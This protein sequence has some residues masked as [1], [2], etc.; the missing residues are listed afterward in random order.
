MG[1]IKESW[2][3]LN[4]ALH[5]L[6]YAKDNFSK[7]IVSLNV[8]DKV[9]R[10]FSRPNVGVDETAFM[11]VGVWGGELCL[12]YSHHFDIDIEIWVM[13]NYGQSESW[14]KLF[15]FPKIIMMSVK[16]G[17]V[18][19]R[20]GRNI[21]IYNPKDKTTR[22]LEIQFISESDCS[23]MDI[24][25][26]LASLIPLCSGTSCRDC[27]C[28]CE[29]EEQADRKWKE[30]FEK[31]CV[32]QRAYRPLGWMERK[33]CVLFLSDAIRGPFRRLYYLVALVVPWSYG[34][35]YVVMCWK[36]EEESM[37]FVILRNQINVSFRLLVY[38]DSGI[39]ASIHDLD[40]KKKIGYNIFVRGHRNSSK[41]EDPAKASS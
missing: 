7:T 15:A 30:K 34:R 17:E 26:H 6:G 27:H 22:N 41:W 31:C 21:V 38:S 29:E 39:C 25:I 1:G 8:G 24:V 37:H 12:L 16:Y 40:L 9:F 10:D 4:G 13:K 5:W 2:V 28:G 32:T 33:T 19:L 23:E 35:N 18:L 3:F 11:T 20:D 36:E 14:I